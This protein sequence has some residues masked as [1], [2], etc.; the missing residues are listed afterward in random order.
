MR[1][2]MIEQLRHPPAEFQEAIRT[3]FRLRAPHMLNTIDRWIAEGEAPP[4]AAT[5][6]VGTLRRLRNELQPLLAVL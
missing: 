3:H 1:F 2:A 5:Q 4:R 6:H